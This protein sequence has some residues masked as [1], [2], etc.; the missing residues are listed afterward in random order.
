MTAIEKSYYCGASTTQIIY[1]TIGGFFDRVAEKHPDSQALILRHQGVEWTYAELQR[2]VDQL[3]AGL[4][5]LGIVPGD[6]VGIWGPNSAEWVLT[7]LA[8]AKLGAIM[9]CINPA[10]RLYEL[11]YALNKVECK[12]LITDESFKTSD[13]LGMLNTLAPELEYCEPGALASTKLPKLKHVIRMGSSSSAGMHNFD[14][15][16]ELATDADRAALVGL[17]TQLKPDDAINIQFTSGT[18]GNPKGATLSHCNIL[19]NGYLTGEAMRL[20]P[21]DKLCIPVPLYHCFGMVLAVLACVSHGATMVFPGEAFD[22]QQTLQTVQDERCTAL[23]G[24]PTM[25]ITELDHPNFSSFDLSSLRT[26]I[27]AGAPCPIE[28]MKRVIS[29]MHMRDILIAYGQTELSPINNI[30]LPDDSLER[31]T[32]TVGRAMPWVEIKVIDDAGHVV[33]VG[34]KG[35]ICTRGYSVMQGY[36]N[37]PEKTAET[38]DAAGWLHSGD[39]AT[40]DACGY[41][42]IVGRIKDMI[43]RGGENVYPREVE[44]FLYQHPAISEVQVFGI[45]DKKMGEEVCAWVQLNEGATLSADDIKAFCKDQITHF[46]IPR[47]IRFVSEYPMTVTGKIQKFVMRDEMLAS[48]NQ[49]T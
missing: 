38:I 7:Q 48:L 32:E 42:R 2:R 16:C 28:V 45:P 13:Y 41:V 34:E 10:Y 18:T 35:E 21:A 12:A 23:H 15:V 29:E 49:N 39:I 33:P 3:A 44:E 9:V 19:N 24:V 4:L 47:H 36:W 8:T 17:Q 37:D 43:I 30:T 20:T 26:G 11:E 14:Q 31:R 5:A 25:F 6:R 1:E 27:M 40:M 46:K 22:P